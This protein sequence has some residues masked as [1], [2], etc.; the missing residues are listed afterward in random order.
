MATITGSCDTCVNWDTHEAGGQIP[1]DTDWGTCNKSLTENGEPVD[2]TSV[3]FARAAPDANFVTQ[4]KGALNCR[5][6]HV[7]SMFV[8]KP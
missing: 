6:D 2:P 4:L 3:A 5:A 8:Q 1:G 7:C